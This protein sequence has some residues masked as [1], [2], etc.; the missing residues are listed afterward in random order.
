MLFVIDVGNTNI[1]YGLYDGETLVGSFRQPTAHQS[2]SDEFGFFIH[3]ILEVQKVSRSDITGII[4]SSVV[5]PLMY[6][7]VNGIRKYLDKEPMIVSQNLE[8]GIEIKIDNPSELGT[9]SIANAVAASSLYEGN[10][11]IVDFGTATTFSAVTADKKFLGG[12]ICPGIRISTEALS[13]Y[14]AKLPWVDLKKPEKTI[15]TNTV[16]SM[17]SGAVYGCAGQ[18]DY[19]IRGMK[20]ELGGKATAIATGGMG[21]LIAPISSSIDFHCPYLTLDGLRILYYKNNK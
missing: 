20:S 13:Q 15:G 4:I 7:L 12:V 3:N 14:A 21:K 8:T 17:R 10:L 5:P 11:I 6:S 18:V 16:D 2:T 19:I 1:V 9:D